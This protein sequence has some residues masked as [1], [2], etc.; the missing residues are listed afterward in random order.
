M[1]SHQKED[2][3][4]HFRLTESCVQSTPNF[5]LDIYGY[6]QEARLV[7]PPKFNIDTQTIIFR[8]YPKFPACTDPSCLTF[9]VLFTMLHTYPA[10]STRAIS[11]RPDLDRCQDSKSSRSDWLR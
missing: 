4:L 6:M 5:N 9:Y 2:L 10:P 3:E 8:I 1:F 7:T 11:P